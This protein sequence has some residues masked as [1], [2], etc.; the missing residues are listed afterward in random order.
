MAKAADIME[1]QAASRDQSQPGFS[2][3]DVVLVKLKDNKH[4]HKLLPKWTGLFVIAQITPEG[5]A[6]LMTKSG[7]TLKG[8]INQ[9]NLKHAIIPKN[10]QHWY[11]NPPSHQHVAAK[12]LSRS[13]RSTLQVPIEEESEGSSEEETETLGV[14]MPTEVQSSHQAKNQQAQRALPL[15]GRA[16]SGQEV[17]EDS[18]QRRQPQSVLD[19][20]SQIAQMQERLWQWQQ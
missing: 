6:E 10:S 16:S 15:K 18:R 8:T 20:H 2:A 12:P 7:L 9:I 13:Q 3:G 14:E 1:R 19:L 11:P 4:K 5:S 17:Q